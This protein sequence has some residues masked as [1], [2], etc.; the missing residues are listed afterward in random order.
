MVKNMTKRLLSVFTLLMMLMMT[1][2]SARA[3]YYIKGSFDNWGDGVEMQQDGNQWTAT[4]AF[5]VGEKFQIVS[6][7]NVYYG[8]PAQ[9]SY[10]LTAEN[11]G[12][13]EPFTLEAN[14][15]DLEIRVAGEY[16]ILFD[17]TTHEMLIGAKAPVTKKTATNGTFEV[18]PTQAIPG[19]IVTITAAPA[20]GYYIEVGNITV[21]K[22]INGGSA[23]APGLKTDAPGVGSTVDVVA[24]EAANTF[25]F[26]MPESPYGAKVSAEFQKGTLITAEMIQPIGDQVYDNGNAITPA[27][28]V[29][30][31]ETTLVEGTDYI[32]VYSDNTNV[33]QATVTVTGKGKYYGDAIAHFNIVLGAHNVVVTNDGNGS[34][35]VSPEGAIEP[36]TLV[37]LTVV[38]NEGYELDKLTVDG[39]DKTSEVANNTYTFTMP[40]ADVVVNATFTKVPALYLTGTFNNWSQDEEDMLALQT[41]DQGKWVCTQE[42]GAGDTFKFKDENG[43]WLGSIGN[44][45]CVVTYEFVKNKAA[46]E[47]TT[48]GQDFTIP[49]AGTWTFTVD[50][51]ANPMTVTIS[52]DWYFNIT[53]E[54]PTNGSV[55]VKDD[56]TKALEGDEVELIITPVAGYQVGTITVK[57]ANNNPVTVTNNKFEMPAADVTVAVTFTKILTNNPLTWNVVNASLAV[58]VG[59]GEAATPIQSGTEVQ[60]GSEVNVTITQTDA[61]AAE[62]TISKVTIVYGTT[63][64]EITAVDGVYTFEMPAAATEIKVEFTAVKHNITVTPNDYVTVVVDPT[65][66]AAGDEVTITVTPND[67]FV[68]TGVTVNDGDVEVTDNGDGTYTFDM[69]TGANGVTIDVTVAAKIQGVSF[70]ADRNWAT[71]IGAYDLVKPAGVEAIYV[72]TGVQ[73]NAVVIEEVNY[74]PANKGVLLFSETAGEN[75]VAELYTGDKDATISTKLVGNATAATNVTIEDYVLYNNNFIRS[76]EGTVAAHRCYL[77]GSVV[78]GNPR[79]LKIGYDGDVPTAIET[80][81]AEGNVAKVMYVNMSGLT[82]DKPFQGINIA[83]VTFTDG[84]T[85]TI[86]LVK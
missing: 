43:N 55:T 26:A 7:E 46:L 33:G 62:W 74:I 79:M 65:T 14:K 73:S 61:Q 34:V 27:I 22:T 75:L 69:P 57:D 58:K 52:G 19:Q 64:T 50:R 1:S 37:T 3:A 53:V 83:V 66:A 49:V 21:E 44:G 13:G 24:G 9:T 36:N 48:P 6:P 84:S 80:L 42:M 2:L 47:M 28:I 16:T 35:G 38:P 82:S 11:I 51:D 30:D 56:K 81:I 67:D 85:K 18:N 5:E 72:V 12:T 29:K 15:Q 59:E 78:Q 45:A 20:D 4:K 63:T 77:P 68:V 40:D 76:E 32:V 25:T 41:N 60:E 8:L 71:Y 70:T 86:K 17:A 31:G 39:V 23:Q 10:W 54:T